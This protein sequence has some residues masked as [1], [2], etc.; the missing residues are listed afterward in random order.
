MNISIICFV[1]GDSQGATRQPAGNDGAAA[2]VA[3][4]LHNSSTGN[5]GAAAGGQQCVR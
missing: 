2:G 3:N 4:N 5:D 1:V